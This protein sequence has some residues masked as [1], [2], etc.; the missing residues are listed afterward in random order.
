MELEKLC[1]GLSRTTKKC[2]PPPQ[3]HLSGSKVKVKHKAV[4]IFLNS[5]LI[6][7]PIP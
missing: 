4:Y 5:L 2:A 7:P 6:I 3:H 1:Q